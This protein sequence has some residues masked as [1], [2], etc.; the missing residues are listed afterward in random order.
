MPAPTKRIL[1]SCNIILA[2][3]SP[4]RKQIIDKVPWLTATVFPCDLPESVPAGTPIEQV[5]VL[6]ARQK[7]QRVFSLTGGVVLGADTVVILG[8]KIL[9]KPSCKEECRQML[10]ELCGRTHSVITGY[11]IISKDK[12]VENFSKTMVTFGAFNR[13]IVY[14]YLE[15]GL[16]MDKA[17]GYG[18]Q[19]EILRPLIV[20]V[21][22]DYQNVIGLPSDTEKALKEFF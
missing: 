12:K 2:S 4:R 7:A 8:D 18:I 22:G 13:E 11:C 9:G 20:G 21:D 10:I 15:S 6:L 3:A 1:K 5:P 14:N 17:G 16:G 19:D